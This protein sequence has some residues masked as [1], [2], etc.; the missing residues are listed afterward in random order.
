VWIVGVVFLAYLILVTGLKEEGDMLFAIVLILAIALTIFIT[1]IN[2]RG[3]R[4]AAQPVRIYKNGIELHVF[5][6]EILFGRRAF[7]YKENIDHLEVLRYPIAQNL[8][9]GYSIVW[10]D[11]P[12]E[13]LVCTKDR[14]KLTTGPKLPGEVAKM[15]D[16]IHE[17]RGIQVIDEGSGMGQAEPMK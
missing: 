6:T 10:K 15:V 4:R 1:E 16:I 12:I 3:D 2:S 5:L 9:N 14:R 11:A 13:I 17:T 8:E 7:V